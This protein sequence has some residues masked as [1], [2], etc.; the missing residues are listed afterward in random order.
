[1]RFR[2]TFELDPLKSP[3]RSN[4][5]WSPRRCV[6]CGKMITEVTTHTVK[7]HPGKCRKVHTAK[8][9]KKNAA[10]LKARRVA[11]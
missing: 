10:R 8:I 9:A 2:P 7:T 3:N 1:M 11:A 5:N 4:S 6:E